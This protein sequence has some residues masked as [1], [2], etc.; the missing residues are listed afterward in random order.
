MRKLIL[1]FLSTLI[2]SCVSP[3]IYLI[4]RQNILEAEAGGEWPELESELLKIGQKEGPTLFVETKNKV[5]Q[6]KLQNV[7]NGELTEK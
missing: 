4:D 7:L 3:Q 6:K 2:T 1:I 5:K